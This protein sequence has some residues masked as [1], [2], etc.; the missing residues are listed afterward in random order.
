VLV[1]LLVIDPS[2][3]QFD[4]EHEHEHEHEWAFP[5]G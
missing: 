3:R 5:A 4:Y 2:G 1:L